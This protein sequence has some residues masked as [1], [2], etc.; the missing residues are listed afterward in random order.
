MVYQGHWRYKTNQN[1]QK[2]SWK[3]GGGCKFPSLKLRVFK[4]KNLDILWHKVMNLQETHKFTRKTKLKSLYVFLFF[5][6]YQW[7]KH[8][9]TSQ[10]WTDVAFFGLRLQWKILW[11]STFQSDFGNRKGKRSWR[12]IQMSKYSIF[13]FIFGQSRTLIPPKKTNIGYIVQMLPWNS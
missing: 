7:R 3:Q 10:G 6:S 5:F 11:N 2:K 12:Q 8:I 1:K 4:K 13:I 9:Y